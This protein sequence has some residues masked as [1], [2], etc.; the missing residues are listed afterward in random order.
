MS[1]KKAIH[2]TASKPSVAILHYSCP[3]VIGGVEFVIEAHA[4]LFGDAG[5][6]TK[7]IVG[8]GYMKHPGVRTV[9]IPEIDSRGGPIADVLNELRNGRVPES[10]NGAVKRVERKL[11]NALRNVDVCMMH[12]VLTMHFNLV[13]TAALA[14]IMKTRK[15]IKFIGWTHDAAFCD[16]NYKAF[17][18]DKY[19]WNLLKN[20]LAGCDYCA[21]SDY[22][23]SQI[24]KLF[25]ISPSLIPVVSDGIDVPGL[26]GLT[27]MIKDIFYTEKLYNMDIIALTPT[28]IVRRKN[29]EAGMEIVAGFKKLGKKVRWFITGAAD[30]HNVDAVTYWNELTKRRRKL[31]IEKE[32]VFMCERVKER[33]SNEDLRALFSVVDMLIFPSTHEGFGIPVLEGGVAGLL[34]VLSDIPAFREIAADNAVYMGKGSKPLLT[35]RK[36]IRALTASP[37]LAFRKKVMAHYSWDSVFT[38]KIVPLVTGRRMAM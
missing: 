38:R 7:I 18:I 36:A 28:R 31:G 34:P 30:P 3:P 6:K 26:L 11:L 22:R 24:A 33:V 19:P 21:I 20:K 13:L 25:G 1:K 16:K 4:K 17:W 29:L 8:N 9:V 27:P 32:V 12:N 35:A 14:N 37:R 15:N 10:F 2:R 5:F 23:R